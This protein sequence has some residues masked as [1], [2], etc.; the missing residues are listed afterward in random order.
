MLGLRSMSKFSAITCLDTH[1]FSKYPVLFGGRANIVRTAV[2]ATMMLAVIL[3]CAD[4]LSKKYI[5]HKLLPVVDQ[6]G[7]DFLVIKGQAFESLKALGAIERTAP[8]CTSEIKSDLIELTKAHRFV[9]ASAIKLENG[10]VCNSYGQTLDGDKFPAE[11][12]GN[13]YRSMG[14]VD[15]WFSAGREINRDKGEVIIAHSDS[16]IWLNKGIINSALNFPAGVEFDLLDEKTLQTV[17]SSESEIWQGSAHSLKRYKLTFDNNQMYLLKPA[18]VQGLLAIASVPVSQYVYA[19]IFFVVFLFAITVTFV[20]FSLKL[21]VQYF[22]LPAKLRIAIGLDRLDIHYQPIVDM[23]TKQWI[24]AEALLRMTLDEENIPPDVLIPMAQRAG[25]MRQLT[26]SV[27]SRVAVDYVSLLWA[28]K[29]FYITI[30]LSADDVMDEDFPEFTK[31]LFAHYQ[32]LCS[33]IVFE[34]T[35]ESLIDKEKAISNLTRLREQGHKIAIDDFGTGYS[36]L[37]YLDIL[38][39]DILKIDRSFIT[40]DKLNYHEGL[41]WH[42][43]SMAR[44]HEL[45]VIAEGIETQEQAD[46]L[47]ATGVVKGQGWLYSKALPVTKLARGF[48][49]IE[50]NHLA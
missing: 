35:E 20:K 46:I 8:R 13:H 33:K 6:V 22:S 18:V 23:N 27:C 49:S 24:G 39:V 17:Y 10:K 47:R 38:P 29:D 15:Y 41:W 9:Y 19:L 25:L 12:H 43:I 48:F 37:S 7:E 36:S 11:H 2:C 14:G 31:R 21:H 30:N 16:Y 44:V 50:Y 3:L 34:I 5:M 4:A 42:I 40:S 1:I 26:R 32:V 28:C 45:T